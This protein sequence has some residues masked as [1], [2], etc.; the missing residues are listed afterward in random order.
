MFLE[1]KYSINQARKDTQMNPYN[2]DINKLE[3]LVQADENA[4][5]VKIFGLQEE[6]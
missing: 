3:S 5:Y 4:T 6:K 2:T 1:I